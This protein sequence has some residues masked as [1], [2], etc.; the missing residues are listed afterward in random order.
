MQVAKLVF[1]YFNSTNTLPDQIILLFNKISNIHQHHTRSLDN[2]CLF[3]QYG[4]LNVRKNSL[5]VYAP[6]L[7][8]T[9]PICLRQINSFSFFSHTFLSYPLLFLTV[10]TSLLH[11]PLLFCSLTNVMILC[12]LTWAGTRHIGLCL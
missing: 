2:L 6:V 8:N 9:I 10:L 5:K 12:F 11:S 4:R 7:W 3:N 1:M